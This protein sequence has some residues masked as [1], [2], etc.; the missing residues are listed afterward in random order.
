MRAIMIIEKNGR[1]YGYGLSA[2][3]GMSREQF[4]EVLHEITEGYEVVL[5]D[6]K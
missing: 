4:V 1:R 6:I 2:R 5:L 3:A